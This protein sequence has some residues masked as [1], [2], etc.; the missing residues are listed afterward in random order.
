M[1]ARTALFPLF[2]LLGLGACSLV[3][4]SPPGPAQTAVEKVASE[5][6]SIARLTVHAM[7]SDETCTVL[8]STD[9]PRIGKPS[10][11]EDLTAMLT[12]KPVVLEEAGACDITV[13]VLKKD[14]KWTHAI[15]VTLKAK[16]GDNR[17]ALTKRAVEIANAV[18]AELGS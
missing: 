14:G 12:G 7:G 3:P 18:A 4:A 8:A 2:L 6:L 5:N 9:G 17:K 1:P 11:K 16:P 13:P 10:D 15:G